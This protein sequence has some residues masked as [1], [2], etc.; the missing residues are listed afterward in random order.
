M[1][2]VFRAGLLAIA[3]ALGG[4]AQAAEYELDAAHSSA[5]FSISHLGF[6]TVHGGLAELSGGFTFDPEKPEKASVQ[7]TAKAAS[8]NT[9]NEGRD[10][11]LRNEDFFNVTK[12]PELSFKSTAWKKTGEKTF[13]VTGEFTLLGVTKPITVPV[14]FNGAGE[15]FKGEQ[16]AGFSASFKIKR[17]EYG[18][19]K[20]VGPVGDEVSIEVSIQ[21][22]KK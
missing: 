1:K 15:G 10:E 8:I 9:F 17:S 5:T 2:K 16:R 21:G 14:T 19:D 11:H 3:V 22:I 12:F 20:S 6:S 7:V 13:D 4:T 18:M